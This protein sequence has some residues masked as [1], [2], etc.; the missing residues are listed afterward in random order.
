MAGLKLPEGELERLV[1]VHVG[2]FADERH[3]LGELG[4]AFALEL[5]SALVV[6]AKRLLVLLDPACPLFLP[7]EKRVLALE[8][9]RHCP[10]P[11]AAV[12]EPDPRALGGQGIIPDPAEAEVWRLSGCGNSTFT[13]GGT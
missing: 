6:R 3:R 8:I 10:H 1:A 11:F 12:L 9:L 5:V 4:A 13:P 7:C 2:A